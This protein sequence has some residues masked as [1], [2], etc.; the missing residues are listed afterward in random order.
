MIDRG[1]RCRWRRAQDE[2]VIEHGSLVQQRLTRARCA[3]VI[4]DQIDATEV[5]CG[6]PDHL[7]WHLPISNPR[8]RA[9]AA[10]AGPPRRLSLPASDCCGSNKLLVHFDRTGE[11]PV[12]SSLTFS[13]PAPTVRRSEAKDPTLHTL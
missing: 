6:R 12:Y 11:S 10:R 3:P 9:Q 7:E 13:L 8:P 2:W 1:V 4:A 5:S